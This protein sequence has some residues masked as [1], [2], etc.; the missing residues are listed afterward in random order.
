MNVEQSFIKST[1]KGRIIEIIEERLNGR[2]KD[3]R[4][5]YPINV[6]DSYSAI[7]AND[8]KRKIAVSSPQNG[9]V[10]LIESKEVNDYALLLQLS[11]ELQTEA[12]AV[13][14]SDITGAW[15]Y[16]EMLEG[17]VT[18]SYFSEEDDEIEDLLETKLNQKKIC[19]PLYLFREVVRER[20]NG[21]DIVCMASQISRGSRQISAS[22]CLTRCPRE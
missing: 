22:S 21:W 12:L 6:P 4:L 20:G 13:I 19:Q 18:E 3:V 10:A 1:E 5:C 11:K 15:G 16:V 17:K 14:Q 7:L 9:W 2:L 8:E